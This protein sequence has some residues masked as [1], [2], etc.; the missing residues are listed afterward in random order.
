[1]LAG[2]NMDNLARL[3]SILATFALGLVFLLIMLEVF[4]QGFD[5][6]SWNFLVTMPEDA[7]RSG[8]IWPVLL[9]TL[10]ILLVCF[11]VVIPIGSLSAFVLNEWPHPV[12]K[13]F[14]DIALDLLAGMPSIV[15]G[16]FGLF[17]FGDVLGFGFSILSGGLT[18]ALM[19]LPFYT[20]CVQD[21]YRY[22][23]QTYYEAAKA[24]S[25]P[26]WRVFLNVTFPCLVPSIVLG[27]ILG[28]SRALAETAALL[29]T[30]GYVT[31][32]PESLLDSG[33]ALSVHIYD[34]AMNVPGGDRQAYGSVF[35]LVALLLLIYQITH[36]LGRFWQRK[37]FGLRSF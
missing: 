20:R 37:L 36:F 12:F 15:F 27:V 3:S 9:S 32:V 31:R 6:L 22:I 11:S 8:G 19:V 1:M 2:N 10:L 14:M 5:V 29:F 34:L 16:L 4:Q 25:L 26:R 23:P 35:V 28:V 7:G 13:S 24:L 18:L 33:R 30:S 17:F 21:G